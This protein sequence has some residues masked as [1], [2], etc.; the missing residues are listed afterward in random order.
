MKKINSLA[1][2]IKVWH[3]TG[4]GLLMLCMT[5]TTTHHVM[6]TPVHPTGVSGEGIGIVITED[7][8]RVGYYHVSDLPVDWIAIVV[9]HPDGGVVWAL[10]GNGTSGVEMDLTGEPSGIYDVSITLSDDT[11]SFTLYKGK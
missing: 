9:R 5:L 8:C 10:D 4:F 7:I 11:A 2:A 6:S 1:R 3:R